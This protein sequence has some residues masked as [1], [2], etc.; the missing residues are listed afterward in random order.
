M[1]QITCLACLHDCSVRRDQLGRTVVRPNCRAKCS[2]PGRHV[3]RSPTPRLVG[4][5]CPAC[6]HP[7]HVRPDQCGRTVVCSNCDQKFAPLAGWQM[8]RVA[9]SVAAV[10]LSV[11]VLGLTVVAA[12]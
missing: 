9:A 8:P 10:A 11:A 5:D 2:A 7:C 6:S 1:P 4:A 3:R 12:H